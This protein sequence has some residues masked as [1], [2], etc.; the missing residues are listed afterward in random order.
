M[1]TFLK[2]AGQTQVISQ[3]EHV[4]TEL[5]NLVHQRRL[6]LRDCVEV[7]QAYCTLAQEVSLCKVISQCEHIETEMCNLVHQRRLRDCV[8]VLQ[9][10]CILAQEVS[11]LLLM[12]IFC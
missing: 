1:V 4:E 3:C 11:L 6:M 5:C 2:T 9:A 10:Y 12:Q 8:E 7:L